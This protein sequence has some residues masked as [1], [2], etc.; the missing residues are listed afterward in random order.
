[1]RIL[2]NLQILYRLFS[3]ALNTVGLD[4]PN[5]IA[6]A[7]ERFERCNG[8]IKTLNNCLKECNFFKQQQQLLQLNTSYT[9]PANKS[10]SSASKTTKRKLP[11]PET[12]SPIKQ[13]K[14]K[15]ETQSNNN[16]KV[17]QSAAKE[18]SFK[19]HENQEIDLTQ[20]HIRIFLSNLD[21][22]LN[23]DE[24]I[25]SLPEIKI[26][27][28]ELI[29]SAN[30]KSRGFGYALLETEAEVEKALALDRKSINGRPVFISSVLRD[31]EQRQKFKYNADKEL[32]KLFIKSLPH[33]CTQ[34]E[35][36]EIFSAYGKLKDVR[37]V[38]HK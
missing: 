32:H 15:T 26:K 10:S 11:A 36:E 23:E 5:V 17:A 38:Y 9:K 21:Y 4:N 8:N 18:A 20:D 3:K 25:S 14:L 30:G 6:S 2:Q 13:P 7:W 16:N 28:F 35:L 31:K 22:N 34:N 29:R 37:L 24:I 1:M 27:N 12:D 19:E 33:D